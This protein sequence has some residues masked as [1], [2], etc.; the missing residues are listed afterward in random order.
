MIIA[1]AMGYVKCAPTGTNTLLVCYSGDILQ[2]SAGEAAETRK[3]LTS[4]VISTIAVRTHKI[5]TPP[6]RPDPRK[7]HEI[8]MFGLSEVGMCSLL[9]FK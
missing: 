6:P 8:K 9:V 7:S 1:G 2:D 5:E 4:T 3:F